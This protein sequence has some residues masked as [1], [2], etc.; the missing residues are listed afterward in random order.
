MPE[1]TGERFRSIV[2]LLS[3]LLCIPIFLFDIML[4]QGAPDPVL[5]IVPIMIISFY[6]RKRLLVLLMGLLT[7]ALSIAGFYLAPSGI[8][9]YSASDLGFTVLALVTSTILGFY[10]VGQTVKLGQL[11]DELK[12]NNE[13][14]EKARLELEDLNRKLEEN[15][16]A[17]NRSNEDLNGFA[18]VASHDLKSPLSTIPAFLQILQ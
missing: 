6:G 15:V 9:G 1:L 4:P 17:L 11:N 18:H 12:R 13:R 7:V 14:L 2:A 8:G 10:I 16:R 3:F 5:F